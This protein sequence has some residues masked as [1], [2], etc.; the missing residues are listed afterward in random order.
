MYRIYMFHVHTYLMPTY[1]HTYIYKIISL[2]HM[3]AKQLYTA[4]VLNN[5]DNIQY[6]LRVFI[7]ITLAN[8]YAVHNYIAP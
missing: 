2:K 5:T 4:Q 6:N 8:N 3:T 7:S 1:T